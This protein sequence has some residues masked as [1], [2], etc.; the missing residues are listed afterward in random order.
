MN[1]ATSPRPTLLTLIVACL[2]AALL[3]ASITWAQGDVLPPE[4]EYENV[5]GDVPLD[6]RPGP[7]TA[8]IARPT[9]QPPATGPE[10]SF[11]VEQVRSQRDMM[12]GICVF[13][14]VTLVISLTFLRNRGT[15]GDIVTVSALNFLIFGTILLAI[16]SQD[17]RQLTAAIGV[18]G[19]IAGYLFRSMGAEGRL[20]SRETRAR[21][22][23]DERRE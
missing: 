14:I 9:V 10:A 18:I 16:V 5:Y 7:P 2:L 6:A 20:D 15:A 12:I 11:L 4:F 17:V 23:R 8:D 13:A 22:D 21:R 19:A 1:A 3:P